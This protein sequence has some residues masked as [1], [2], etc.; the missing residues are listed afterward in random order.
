MD[1]QQIE[2]EP[3]YNTFAAAMQVM[4]WLGVAV[5]CVF[6]LLYVTGAFPATVPI[7]DCMAN[8]DRPAAEFWQATRGWEVNGY[9]WFA[10]NLEDMDSLSLMGIA[11][12][13]LCPAVSA[14]FAPPKGAPCAAK[15]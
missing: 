14:A 3:M 5:L 13:A 15:S 2:L 4:T 7:K 12:L 6:G 11:L 8:W 10:L 1:E 9:G